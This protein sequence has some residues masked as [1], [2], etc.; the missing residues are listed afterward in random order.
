MTDPMPDRCPAIEPGYG[1]L[2]RC[3]FHVGHGGYHLASGA[4]PVDETTS[5]CTAAGAVTGGRC[6][7]P[8]GHDEDD[9]TA[10]LFAGLSAPQP[11]DEPVSVPPP[12]RTEFKL[13]ELVLDPHHVP[14]EHGWGRIESAN[15]VPP[16]VDALL[17][18]IDQLHT[19]AVTYSPT[20]APVGNLVALRKRLDE[21]IGALYAAG[22]AEGRRQATEEARTAAQIS[23]FLDTEEGQLHLRKLIRTGQIVLPHG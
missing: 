5:R 13:A 6:V 19:W 7:L 11:A 3:V 18:L 17:E 8:G 20:F 12:D 9:G 16:P 23:T 22:V 2:E 15:P 21:G 14:N 10:H 4:W 1:V